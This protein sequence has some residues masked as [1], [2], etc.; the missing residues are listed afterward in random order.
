MLEGSVI[1]KTFS[2][3]ALLRNSSSK[4]SI[5]VSAAPLQVSINSNN[6]IDINYIAR[7]VYSVMGNEK[8][9]RHNFAEMSVS[10]LLV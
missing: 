3:A 4:E 8:L 7:L 9:R 5:V 10:L 6:Q 2:D 1:N